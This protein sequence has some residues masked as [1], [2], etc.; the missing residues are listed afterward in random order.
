[1]NK[2]EF[3]SVKLGERIGFVFCPGESPEHNQGVVTAKVEVSWGFHV[4][5]K[6]EDGQWLTVEGFTDK[7]IG[8]YRLDKEASK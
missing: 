8:C 5:V 6:K 4:S 2:Q 3:E 7:G 1:M